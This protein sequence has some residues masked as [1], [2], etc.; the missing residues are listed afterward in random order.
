MTLPSPSRKSDPW[1]SRESIG[2]ALVLV[3]QTLGW[4][5]RGV[6]GGGTNPIFPVIPL[7]I[8]LGLLA[9]PQWLLS[10]KLYADPGLLAIPLLVLVV[11]YVLLTA[12]DVELL[13]V[14][15]YLIFIC[16]LA[17]CIALNPPEQFETLPRAVMIVGLMSSAAPFIG[18]LTNPFSA[19]GRLSV[20]G[21]D[22]V[23]ITGTVGGITMVSSILV[24]DEEGGNDI[25]V[26]LLASIAFTIGLGALILSDKRSDE[27]IMFVVVVVYAV[28]RR[29][30]VRPSGARAVGRQ[31]L[32]FG[33]VLIGGIASLPALATI[34]LSKYA[35][36][37]FESSSE[38]HHSGFFNSMSSGSS[39]GA[40]TSTAGRFASIEFAYKRL[41]IFGVGVMHQPSMQGAGE[42]THMS[43]LQA[44][45]DLGVLGGTAFLFVMALM[46]AALSVLRTM[47]APLTQKDI[48]VILLWVY[49][50][51]DAL[52]HGIPYAWSILLAALLVYVLLF[53]R[54][55]NEGEENAEPAEALPSS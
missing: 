32:V 12:T 51:G 45:Y 9:K 38:A 14:C 23:L 44:Y 6:A 46:P 27:L 2:L 47:L 10:N 22:D 21:N 7:V 50:Q 15:G 26:G 18:L 11:P 13:P 3:G 41:S 1:V 25:F 48:F 8:A 43:Y 53:R 19:L 39:Y 31:R 33:S 55:D 34:F 35:L 29:F 17:M 16:I 54:A 40:D 4:A 20:P 36:M 37:F 30:R 42:Y 5:V 52:T 49:V 24:G 28:L